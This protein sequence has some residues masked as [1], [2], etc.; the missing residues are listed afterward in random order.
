M[1]GSMKVSISIRELEILRKSAEGLSLDQ[2]AK[3]LNESK[4]QISQAQTVIMLKTGSRDLYS[5]LHVLAKNGFV[6]AESN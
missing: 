1:L 3:D 5:A 6:F 4:K 2:I